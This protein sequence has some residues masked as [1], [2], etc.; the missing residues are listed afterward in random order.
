MSNPKQ[1]KVVHYG[2]PITKSNAH[3][4]KWNHR[5]KKMDVFIDTPKVE[6]ENALRE[7][8]IKTVEAL[9]LTEPI[10]GP[11]IISIRY[12]LG[13]RRAKDLT[14]LPKTTCDALNG[15]VYDDDSMIVKATLAKYYD[16]NNPRVEIVVTPAKDLKTHEW[17]I[18]ER[19]LGENP[20]R[21]KSRRATEVN[22]APK[23]AYKPK[24][25]RTYKRK[26]K[27]R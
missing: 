18:A 6:Y 5:K 10:A 4:Y 21:A 19:F 17:P 16:K 11:V 15:V 12:F 13:S 7:T 27:K 9:G 22:S 23:P 14:N 3:H 2:E 1:I 24:R 26:L 20:D 8:A 25:K